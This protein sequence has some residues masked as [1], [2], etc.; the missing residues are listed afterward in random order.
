MS[1]G[2][3]RCEWHGFRSNDEDEAY[4][5]GFADALEHVLEIIEYTDEGM[6]HDVKQDV[7]NELRSILNE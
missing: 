5:K 2:K 1:T 4:L 3:E 7:E 6:L